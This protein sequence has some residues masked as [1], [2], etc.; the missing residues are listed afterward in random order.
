[1][2]GVALPPKI[3]NVLTMLRNLLLGFLIFAGS[4][5]AKGEAAEGAYDA[6]LFSADDYWG[7][8]LV[9]NGGADDA[10]SGWTFSGGEF[11]RGIVSTSYGARGFDDAAVPAG[12]TS[13][14]A[15]FYGGRGDWLSGGSGDKAASHQYVDLPAEI[16]EFVNS[17]SVI[18]NMSALLGGYESQNDYAQVVYKF[19]DARETELASVTLGPVKSDDRGG[20]TSMLPKSAEVVVPSGCTRVKVEVQIYEQNMG[21]DV[22]GYVDNISLF[23]SRKTLSANIVPAKERFAYKEE[24]RLEYSEVPSN[25]VIYLYKDESLLPMNTFMEIK[26]DS[27]INEGVFNVGGELEPGRY[28]VR[29]I[30]SDGLQSGSDAVFHVADV[31]MPQGDMNIFVMSDIHVMHPSL[32]VSGGAAFEEYLESDRKLLQESETILAAMVDSVLEFRPELVMISGDLTKDGERMSHELVAS[33][34][35]KITDAGI[36]VLVV[37][38]NHDV[39]NPHALIYNGDNTEYA[40]TV[41]PREFAEIYAGCGYGDA[42]LRDSASLSYVSEPSE[43]LAVICI[44]ACRYE[45]NLFLDRGDSAD[46]CVTDGRIKPETLEWIRHAAER[47]RLRGRQVIAM[48]HHNL[49]EHFNRQAEIA[50]PYVVADAAAV[51]EEFMKLGIHVVFTGHFHISDIAKGV[52]DDGTGYVYDIATGSTVTYPCPFRKL[53]LGAGNTVLDV[54]SGIL[55]DVSLPDGEGGRFGVYAR[56][57]VIDGIPSMVEGVLVDYWDTVQST[58]DGYLGDNPLVG[59]MVSLPETPEEMA[60]LLVRHLGDVAAD[61]YITFSEGNEHLKIT[62]GIMPEI[63]RGID[64][65]VGEVVSDVAQGTASGMV[66]EQIMPL[67]EEVIGSM[68]GNVTAFNTVN[69]SISNDHYISVGLDDV[70]SDIEKYIIM[71]CIAGD[72]GTVCL[73]REAY[74]FNAEIYAVA[75]VD[76]KNMPSVLYLEECGDA[77]LEAGSPYLFKVE[78][79]GD[80]IF[81]YHMSDEPVEASSVSGL[82]GTLTDVSVSAE[83]ANFL[84][85]KRGGDGEYMWYGATADNCSVAG[86][87]AWLDLSEV[88]VA[89]LSKEYDLSIAFAATESGVEEISPDRTEDSA[90]V[91]VYSLGGVVVR[92][93]IE[94][95]HA[96]DGLPTGVYIVGAGGHYERVIVNNGR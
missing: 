20:V 24:V 79:D 71:D 56:D 84:L 74:A 63:E 66:K 15:L 55:R 70:S 68:V 60:D 49:V 73:P 40:E 12:M 69:A 25:S 53:T 92:R 94:R 85:D 38:G 23:L 87:M 45:D 41:T 29:C 95:R 5:S 22:D 17:A 30:K 51:R 61:V 76:D 19:Y 7:R 4:V 32:L 39:D 93:N 36:K 8:E 90:I 59:S 13:S 2:V 67:L 91:D 9:V 58:I 11:Y 10:G 46:V 89:D 28:T 57:K 81:S 96:L 72:L 21:Y 35:E 80:A 50:S 34:L 44:D 31:D 78:D 65:I 3:F 86:N 64:G 88:P 77:L 82:N 16:C 43:D 33:Y 14:D 27:H 52:S 1:M 75:G 42:V 26:G 48:M 62:E 6:G 83:A 54:V 18:A 37:P 47:E